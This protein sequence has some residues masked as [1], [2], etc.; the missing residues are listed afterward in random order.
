[1][2]GYWTTGGDGR[3]TTVRKG[4]ATVLVTAVG[5]AVLVAAA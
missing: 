3:R 4:I 2:S 5:A 1:M